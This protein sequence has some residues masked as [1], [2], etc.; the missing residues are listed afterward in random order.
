MLFKTTN[1][2]FS[3]SMTCTGDQSEETLY[4]R[5]TT[6]SDLATKPIP[7]TNT[8][9]EN[10]DPAAESQWPTNW[11]NRTT[12][13]FHRNI[14]SE[15]VSVHVYLVDDSVLVRWMEHRSLAVKMCPAFDR[16]TASRTW[17]QALSGPPVYFFGQESLYML[18]CTS[19]SQETDSYVVCELSSNECPI[20]PQKKST[21]I[22]S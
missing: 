15:D 18:P 6:L 21:L 22:I 1:C 8:E 14:K 19:W 4:Q 16:K 3:N 9:D 5:T 11:A 13:F 20:V 17:V 2:S 7:H 12:I 10:E